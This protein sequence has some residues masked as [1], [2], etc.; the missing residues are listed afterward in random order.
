MLH[1]VGVSQLVMCYGVELSTVVVHV[2]QSPS[3]AVSG[4]VRCSHLPE[5]VSTHQ[6]NFSTPQLSIEFIAHNLTVHMN[7][8]VSLWPQAKIYSPLGRQWI[9]IKP[10]PLAQQL[11]FSPSGPNRLIVSVSWI[12]HI[13]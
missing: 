3:V 6:R 1:G 8:V 10:T 12:D 5:G 13:K 7:K 2:R 9:V 11:H 4:V